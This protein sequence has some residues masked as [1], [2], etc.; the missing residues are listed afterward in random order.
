V[1]LG[2]I[3]WQN[4]MRRYYA[5]DAAIDK[6]NDDKDD[7]L[8]SRLDDERD[9][10]VRRYYEA[11]PVV[12]MGV[13]PYDG[14]PVAR[15][16][17]PF[18]FDGLRWLDPAGAGDK[19]PCIH[20]V[21]VRGAVTFR[22]KTPPGR[23]DTKKA[24]I[25]PDV[26]FV[27]PRLLKLEGMVAVM[28]ALAMDPGYQAYT[29][30]YFGDPLPAPQDGVPNWC[31]DRFVFVMADGKQAWRSDEDPWDFELL[32]WL[33]SGKLRWCVPGFDNRVLATEP[34]DACPYANLPG[35]REA[36][37]VGRRSAFLNG[38]PDGEPGQ[39]IDN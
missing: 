25:G 26:P 33:R 23:G 1:L 9:D 38:T 34:P 24:H 37:I 15:K 13:C 18:G 36:Q 28:G 35:H 32:P 20:F 22:G 8:S 16:F 27:I 5:L 4:V 12:G 29:I 3:D 7:A 31:E 14:I 17:D 6:A 11:L 39:P 21:A 10:L 19:P 2:K 30:T